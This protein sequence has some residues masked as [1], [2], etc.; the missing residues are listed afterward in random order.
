MRS[1]SVFELYR[2]RTFSASAV[3]NLEAAFPGVPGFVRLVISQPIA[4]G[5]DSTFMGIRSFA[6]AILRII[7]VS[8]PFRLLQSVFM[9]AFSLR[10]SDRSS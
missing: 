9:S 4:T 3:P 5:A 8:I 2:N 10:V 6:A 7:S 1:V